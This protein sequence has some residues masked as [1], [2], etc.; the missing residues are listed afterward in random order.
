MLEN[1]T[2]M[3]ATRCVEEGFADSV[4][5]GEV[6]ASAMVSASSMTRATP[7]EVRKLCQRWEKAH[8]K[9]EPEEDPKDPPKDPDK[10]PDKEE[11]AKKRAE[12]I[13]RAEIAR[14]ASI[15]ASAG[16]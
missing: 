8:A 2:W 11:E 9:Q 14:R 1:E 4:Y 5:G 3:S 15:A 12:I 16:I 7:E 6:R 13:R 10:D